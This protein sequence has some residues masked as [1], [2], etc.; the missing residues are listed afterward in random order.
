MRLYINF[1][2]SFKAQV[3]TLCT[4]KFNVTKKKV[5]VLNVEFIYKIISLHTI[6]LPVHIH[7]RLPLCHDSTIN[8]TFIS[9]NVKA[10]RQQVIYL[11]SDMFRPRR[12]YS[13]AFRNAV[14]K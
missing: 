4:T 10:F 8:R 5:Y 1:S 9:Q 7:K 14:F 2:Q 13:E 3:A 11:K 6:N 12:G